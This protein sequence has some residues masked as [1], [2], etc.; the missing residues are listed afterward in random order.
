MTD[1][2]AKAVS[3]SATLPDP[4]VKGSVWRWEGSLWLV[5]DR[6]SAVDPDGPIICFSRGYTSRQTHDTRMCT[7]MTLVLARALMIMTPLTLR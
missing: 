5:V 6:L 2:D 4:F 3:L 1:Q 7:R